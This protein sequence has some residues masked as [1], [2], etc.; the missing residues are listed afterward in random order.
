MKGT[1]MN[2]PR[3]ITVVLVLTAVASAA[4]AQEE[5][6]RAEVN[7]ELAAAIRSGDMITPSGLRLKDLSPGL[8]PAD[9]VLAGKTRK[10]VDA[11][12]AAAERSGDMITPSGLRLKDLSP[13]FYPAA[14]VLAGK[15][16]E[17]VKAETAAAIRDGDMIANGESGMTG[18]QL[19]PER[20][21]HQRTI[22]GVQIL[23]HHSAPQ[24]TEGVAH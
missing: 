7:A 19:Q 10:E 1:V 22:D 17:E 15:T 11:E 3:N 5:M 20:Y 2:Y 23:A 16:R 6:T 24:T 9:H 12:L 14:P 21:A 18:Y 8:Y 4:S 13:G